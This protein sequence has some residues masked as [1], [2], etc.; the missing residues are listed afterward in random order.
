VTLSR[1]PCATLQLPCR[2]S[3][4]LQSHDFELMSIVKLLN[5]KTP[6]AK[7]VTHASTYSTYLING[8]IDHFPCDFQRLV[9]SMCT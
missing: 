6:M 1:F 7:F 5:Q 3:D 2:Q 8:F 9:H 4:W